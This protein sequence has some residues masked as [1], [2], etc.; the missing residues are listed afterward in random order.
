MCACPP[1]ESF[2]IISSRFS[3]CCSCLVPGQKSS[4]YAAERRPDSII[5]LSNLC[6][7]SGNNRLKTL[8]I[9]MDSFSLKVRLSRVVRRWE[10]F[11]ETL[12]QTTPILTSTSKVYWTNRPIRVVCDD[13]NKFHCGETI[14]TVGTVCNIISVIWRIVRVWRNGS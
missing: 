5:L 7:R 1:R 9:L 13:M 4:A 6:L 2:L 10:Y 11:T 12:C 14:S 3:E 8:L